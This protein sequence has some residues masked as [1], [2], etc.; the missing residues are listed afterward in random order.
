MAKFSLVLLSVTVYIIA[1]L[2]WFFHNF[3]KPDYLTAARANLIFNGNLCLI[4]SAFICLGFC[5]FGYQKFG[6]F[7]III[8]LLFIIS[9][10]PLKIFLYPR[11]GITTADIVHFV[12][13]INPVLVTGA[14]L[15]IFFGLMQLSIRLYSTET[16]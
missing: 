12:T 11:L 8:W 7:A 2:I 9:P 14:G 1:H 16:F 5:R 3:D 6:K 10:I 13:S 15:L 4:I